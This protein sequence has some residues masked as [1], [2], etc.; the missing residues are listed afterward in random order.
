[1][2]NSF[3][4]AFPGGSYGNFIGWTCKWLIDDNIDLS[5]R[6]WND[7]MNNSH[8]WQKI[9]HENI[10]D[11]CAN[12]SSGSL[13]HP[14]NTEHCD[15]K[16]NIDSLLSCYDR[17]LL[18]YPTL[19][20]MLWSCNNKFERVW[21]DGWF[22]HNHGYIA[23]NLIFWNGAEEPWEKREF[24]SFY[25]YKQHMSE[26]RLESIPSIDNPRILKIPIDLIRDNFNEL[27]NNIIDFL[28][29]KPIR[30]EL[31]IQALYDDWLLRQSHINKD[32]LIKDIIHA[33]INDIDMIMEDLTLIDTSEIQRILREEYGIAIKCY[34][35][36]DWP[37]TVKE[38]KPL[39]FRKEDG[40]DQDS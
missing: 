30:T 22:K 38:L 31:D 19:D 40:K 34:G 29:L 3:I 1:M 13:V 4:I 11:A 36:N 2:A 15:L 17:V 7:S 8:N 26:T 12:F 24:L 23:K 32:R 16:E 9:H 27:I 25:L 37:K 6:P 18:L 28:D 20:S 14:I 5:V 21:S 10:E 33:I 35:L 39:L